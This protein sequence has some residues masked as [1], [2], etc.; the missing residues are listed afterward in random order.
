[1]DY[2]D[3]FTYDGTYLLVAEDGENL[4]SRKLPLANLVT[5][6]FRVNNHAHV[7][8]GTDKCD[9]QILG[10]LLNSMNLAAYVTGSTQPKLSQ[11]NLL[12]IELDLPTIDEQRAVMAILGSIDNKIAVNQQTNGYL[13]DLLDALFDNLIANESSDWETASL[14]DIASYKNG[15]AMQR[16]RPVGDDPGLPVLKIRELG[17]GYCGSDAERCCSEH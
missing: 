6:K 14:L 15:L 8:A 11:K 13:A 16:F 4:R 3:D 1:M 9:I 2:L 17:Q 12:A 10:W 7:L 5:G